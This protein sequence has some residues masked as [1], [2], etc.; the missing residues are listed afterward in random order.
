MTTKTIIEILSLLFSALALVISLFAL[1]VSIWQAIIQKNQLDSQKTEN[2]P[3]FEVT[4]HIT[5]INDDNDTDILSVK[6]IGKQASSIESVQRK[7]FIEL[8]CLIDNKTQA[9]FIPVYGYYFHAD[10]ISPG[11]V[12]DVI[13]DITPGNNLNFY[14]FYMECINES[15]ANKSN[16]YNCNLKRFVIISYKD[17]YEEAHVVYFVNEQKCSKDYYFDVQEKSEET[18]REVTFDISKLKLDDVM[19]YIKK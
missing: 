1:G 4:R 11:L 9:V 14:R 13:N 3:I 17:I 6:N 15:N 18:F 12:G 8:N 2:Q 10:R 7:T 19:Q 5:K 16:Y